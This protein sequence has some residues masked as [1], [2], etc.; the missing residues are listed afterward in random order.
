MFGMENGN[1]GAGDEGQPL[2]QATEAVDGDKEGSNEP[3]LLGLQFVLCTAAFPQ[4][5]N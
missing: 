5:E 3:F 4:L 2:L 1:E